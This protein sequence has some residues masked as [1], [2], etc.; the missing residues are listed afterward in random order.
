[1]S[2]GI[3]SEN[4][5]LTVS[6]VSTASGL[7]VD[8]RKECCGSPRFAMARVV[9]AAL[10]F[11][12]EVYEYRIPTGSLARRNSDVPPTKSDIKQGVGFSE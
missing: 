5:T 3:T 11:D 6:A 4:G 2:S 7:K 12:V 1:M 8:E 10:K 9:G